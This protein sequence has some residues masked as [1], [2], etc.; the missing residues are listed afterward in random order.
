MMFREHSLYAV[1]QGKISDFR[2]TM[3]GSLGAKSRHKADVI[4]SPGKSVDTKKSLI[5]RCEIDVNSVTSQ[6][7]SHNIPVQD[8]R[9]RGP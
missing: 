8:N 6:F 9:T 3:I 7:T 2:R 4:S 5:G 1:F